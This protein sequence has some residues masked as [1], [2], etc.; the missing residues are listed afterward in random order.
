LIKRI[1]DE[2][3]YS[4]VEVMVAIMLLAIAII[5]MVGMFDAGLRAAVVGSNYD[6]ARAI[7]GEELEEIKAL[8]FR[9]DQPAGVVDSAVEFYPP[10]NGPSPPPGGSTPCSGVGAPFTCQVRTAYLN[11]ATLAEDGAART[12][13]SVQ[14]TVTWSGGGPYTTTGLTSKETL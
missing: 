11:P 4:L 12:M 14:I 1:K 6:R 13:M 5:P 2:S 8:P 7:A 9:I 10:A 3:G